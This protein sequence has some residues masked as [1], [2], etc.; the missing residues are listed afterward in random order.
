MRITRYWLPALLLAV[1]GCTSAPVQ[2]MSDARQA[3][4]AAEAVN[5]PVKAPNVYDTAAAHMHY[6]VWALE[7]G[8]YADAREHAT[9]AKWHALEARERALTRQSRT[10]E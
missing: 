9:W 8:D 7:S 1:S 5:A 3:V 10:D 6:A 2:E 4:E